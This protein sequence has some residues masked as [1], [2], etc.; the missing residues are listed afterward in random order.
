MAQLSTAETSRLAWQNADDVSQAWPGGI[1]GQCDREPQLV[2]DDQG[3][4]AGMATRQ[5]G[6]HHVAKPRISTKLGCELRLCAM[7]AMGG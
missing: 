2:P 1:L 4:A 3:A 7:V 6:A 5:A